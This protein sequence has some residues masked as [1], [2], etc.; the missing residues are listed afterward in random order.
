MIAPTLM[1]AAALPALGAEPASY[2]LAAELE[3]PEAATLRLD[4]GADWLARCPDPSSYML[5]DNA[6]QEVPFAGRSSDEGADW[7]REALR[8]EPVRSDRGWAWKVQPPT[9]GEPAHALRFSKLP[10]GAVVEVTVQGVGDERPATR[11][12]LW[13]LPDTGAGTRMELP[14]DRTGHDGPWMVRA[15]WSEGAGWMRVGRDLGFEAVVAQPWTVNTVDLEVAPQGPVISGATTSDWQLSLPRAGLPLRGLALEV[16]DPLFSR[17][18][19]LLEATPSGRL[20]RVGRG[21]LERLNY[22]ESWVDKTSLAL[23]HSAASELLLRL[24]DGRS[25]PLQLRGAT[26]TLRGQAL[27]VPGVSGGSYTLL[28]CGPVGPGYDLE[29]LDDRLAELPA[30]QVSAPAPGAHSDWVPAT[31]GLGLL[32]AGPELDREGFRWERP[33]L[34]ATGLVRVPLDDHVLA[35]TRLGQ[36][37]LRF[38]DAQGRQLPF[39]LHDEPMGRLQPDLTPV[40]SEQG[41]ESHLVLALPQASLPALALVLRSDRT[42]F[43]R[44]VT[45][46]DGAVQDGHTLAQATWKGAEEGESRLVLN[47]DD[48]LE[49]KITVVIHNGDNPSLPVESVELVTR[50]S[51][52]WLALPEDGGATLVYGHGTIARPSYDLALLRERVLTQPVEPASLGQPV[53]LAPAPKEPPKKGLLL[54]AVATMSAFLLGLIIRFMKSPDDE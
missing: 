36:P 35:I 13:N 22:G 2:P 14:L 37:D 31:A 44:Q 45:V 3:L 5:L 9:S 20:D 53:A 11:A 17:E 51:S 43:E 38:V 30:Q 7:R 39:L 18:L 34:G 29:R 4:L 48:R 26:I 32:A 21:E 19:T 46:Y 28:G 24:D 25:A 33:V 12:V 27:V 42:L 16:A 6:G 49:K 50:A 8:W 41:A 15:V 10:W 54:V 52:A 47:L 1:F 23:H 40:R